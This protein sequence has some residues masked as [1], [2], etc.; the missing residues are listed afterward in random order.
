[1]KCRHAKNTDLENVNDILATAFSEEPVH[2]L[3]FPGRDRDSLI[4]VLRNFFRIYVNLASKYGGIL[5]TENDAGALVYFRPESMPMPK[6][7]LTQ[8]DNQ[9]RKVCGADYSKAVAFIDG[10]EQYHPHAFR[11]YYISLLAVKPSFRGKSLVDDLFS[12]LNTIL[13]KENLP[14]Y[15]ECTR[16]S[17]RTLIRRWGYIDAGSPISIDG[18]PKLY[19]IMRY[20][21]VDEK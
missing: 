11:H 21:Q 16:F 20:P 3:I 14:C 17:T 7:E 18:F 1:M 9:L 4:D 5:L 8:I 10:L 19:P 12:E 2:K 15:A 6:E 13:D